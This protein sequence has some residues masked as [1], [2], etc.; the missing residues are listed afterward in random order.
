MLKIS[1]PT[2]CHEDWNKMTPNQQ[3][4][5]CDSCMKTVVDFTRMTDDEVKYFLLNNKEEHACGRFTSKQLQ[6]IQIELPPDIFVIQMP[7]W[8]RFLVACLIVFGTTLFSCEVRHPDTVGKVIKTAKTD[9]IIHDKN[10]YSGKVGMFG[11]KIEDTLKVDQV[12]CSV[13]LGGF[14]ISKLDTVATT[15]YPEIMGDIEFV[16]GDT[17]VPVPQQAPVDT[18]QQPTPQFKKGEIKFIPQQKDSGDCE[19]FS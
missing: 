18:I 17:T 2:P 10:L 1:I 11:Y 6:T 16:P 9:S 4:R 7:L 8:K 14:R 5:H 19:N 3:G 15:T 12:N 13:V